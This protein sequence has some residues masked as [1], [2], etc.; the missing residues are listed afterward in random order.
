MDSTKAIKELGLPQTP[1]RETIG[2]TV[3]WY[4]ENGYW[5]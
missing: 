3:A 2:R 4:K 5:G 1:L